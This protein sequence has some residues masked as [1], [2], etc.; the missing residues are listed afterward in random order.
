MEFTLFDGAMG[1]QLLARG[2]QSG[3]LPELLCITE[4]ETIMEIHRDYVAAGAQVITANTFGANRLK[5]GDTTSVDSVVSAAIDLAKRAGAQKVALDIGPTGQLLEPMGDLTYEEAYD[6]FREMV[7]AGEKA[8]A[9]IVLIET[10]SDLNEAKAALLAAK[11][12]SS[13]PVYV[14]MTFTESG[15]TF[16]GVD[17]ET[18]AKTLSSLGADVVGVN[19]SLG[20]RELLPIVQVM[21]QSAACPVMVQPNAGLPEVING[22]TVYRI[23]PSEF[24]EYISQMVDIGVHIVGGCCGTSPEHI[25]ALKAMLSERTE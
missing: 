19:C 3:S 1:T 21:T 8:G 22:E 12:N 10:M 11:E 20:P 23:G 7:I 17:A 18:A 2:L 24:A 25:A 6:A 16:L 5:L 15:R 9:D 14:T 13:L 4:P